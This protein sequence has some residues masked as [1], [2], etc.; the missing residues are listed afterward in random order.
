SWSTKPN[1]QYDTFVTGPKFSSPAILGRSY[2][3]AG[4]GDPVF[5]STQVDV[6]WGDLINTGA[7][8]FTIARLTMSSG[9]TGTVQGRVASISRP[10]NPSLFSFNLSGGT[11]TG[12]IGGV[13]YNDANGNTVRDSGEAG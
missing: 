8:T 9:A 1:L 3:S 6:A 12:S 2:L 13:V 4:A 10:N 11:T 5:S 7:G